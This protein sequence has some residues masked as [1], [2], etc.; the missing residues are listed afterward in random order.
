MPKLSFGGQLRH[1]WNLFN[2]KDPS[3]LY[4]EPYGNYVGGPILWDRPGRHRMMPS[5]DS[6]IATAIYNKIAVDVAM[7]DF[8]HVRVDENGNFLAG[9]KSGLNEVLST[10]ANVDQ[11]AYQFMLDLTLSML[12]EGVVAVVPI[13][14]DTDLIESGGYDVLSV[15]TAKIVGWYPQSV[16][17]DVYNDRT[18]RH[19]QITLPKSKVA[20]IENPFYSVMNEPNSTLKRLIRKLALLDYVDEQ[21]GSGKLNLIIQLPYIIKS[22]KRKQQATERKQEIEDQLEN[23]KYGIAYTDGTEH[24]TQLNR[25]VDNNLM[26]QITSLTSTLYSQLGITQEIMDGTADESTM[27]NYYKRTVDPVV[28]AI[29][30]EFV[31]KFLTKTARTQR[32]TILYYR[33]PFNLTTPSAMAEIADKF[34]RNEVLSPNEVR[35]IVGYKPSKDP[36]ADELR[37]RNI[38]Q[39]GIADPGGFDPEEDESIWDQQIKMEESI[40]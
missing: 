30:E 11:T 18:G 13:D 27:Q 21:S 26:D 16:S 39:N 38:N 15:R 19:E 23:S 28:K 22:S 14:T 2:N 8:R 17:V 20:I 1:A 32:Q 34:T 6:T 36:S 29:V 31:R 5:T 25:P 40:I 4:S 10:E 7:G 9:I 35:G 37:N 3:G 33:N 12:D 24:I